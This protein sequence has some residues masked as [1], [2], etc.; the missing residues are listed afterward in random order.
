MIH[1]RYVVFRS[2]IP[3]ETLTTFGTPE[4]LL[5]GLKCFL[6]GGSM[7]RSGDRGEWRIFF[8]GQV[9]PPEIYHLL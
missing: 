5:A 3:V 2:D 9:L 6:P 1:N 4:D 7:W 8:P